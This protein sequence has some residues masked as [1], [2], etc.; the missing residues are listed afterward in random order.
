MLRL[1]VHSHVASFNQS[2]C[3][4]LA[5]MTMAQAWSSLAEGDEGYIGPSDKLLCL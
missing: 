1:N 4:I 2:K 3:L 5:Q